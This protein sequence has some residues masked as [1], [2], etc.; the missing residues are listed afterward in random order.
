M[1]SYCAEND[2]SSGSQS[3]RPAFPTT[4]STWPRVHNRASRSHPRL[5]TGSLC[6]HS[7]GLINMLRRLMGYWTKEP[8]YVKDPKLFDPN[9]P[10]RPHKY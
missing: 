1:F 9:R 10:F 3:P 6:I 7:K 2:D 5:A 8:E 4:R